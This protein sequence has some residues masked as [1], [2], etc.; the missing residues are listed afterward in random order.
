MF[1]KRRYINYLTLNHIK[2]NFIEPIIKQGITC[3]LIT[4]N[5]D[6]YYKNTIELNALR[7]LFGTGYEENFVIIE[8]PT[9][10]KFGTKN[11]LLVPWIPTDETGWIYDVENSYADICC[12]HFEIVG[13]K[14]MKGITCDSGTSPDLFSKFDK[15]YAGHFHLPSNN[16]NIIYVGSPYQLTWNDYGDRKRIIVYDTKTGDHKDVRFESTELF[17]K[18][19]YDSNPEEIDLSILKSHTRKFIKLVVVSKDDP[20]VFDLF[21]QKIIDNYNPMSVDIIDNTMYDPSMFDG[22]QP[23]FEKGTIAIIHDS[24]DVLEELNVPK[25]PL[26]RYMAALY[27]QAI[28]FRG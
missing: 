28:A 22:D 8:K 4:G 27:N 21:Y 25:E 13:A 9:D 3:Y 26:K 17:V 10:V 20:Y 18:I 7:E 12:G 23:A 11:F 19:A 15:V 14:M 1:D 2:R 24:I 5:H 16:G 6:S